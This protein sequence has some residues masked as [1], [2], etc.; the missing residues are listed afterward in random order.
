MRNIIKNQ[1]QV[2]E[3]SGRLGLA[4]RKANEHLL[5]AMVAL[6]AH[7]V[8][9]RQYMGDAVM[10][11]EELS[12]QLF[13]ILGRATPYQHKYRSRWRL[14]SLQA[15]GLADHIGWSFAVLDEMRK[16]LNNDTDAARFRQVQ[17]STWTA[18]FVDWM[19]VLTQRKR[20][21]ENGGR[22]Q[23]QD[24]HEREHLFTNKT[25]VGTCTCL[26]YR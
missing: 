12:K 2:M 24:H 10:L 16:Q 6:R 17:S 18:W 21:S 1:C 19:C 22:K 7:S 23:L 11:Y 13:Q 4:L 5:I 15:N 3:P 14:L 20:T 8:G 9:E 25:P 26:D